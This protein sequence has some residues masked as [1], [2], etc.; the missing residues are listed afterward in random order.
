MKN[1][2]KWVCKYAWA[3]FTVLAYTVLYALIFL[4]IDDYYD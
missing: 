4:G 1:C 2:V 3:T